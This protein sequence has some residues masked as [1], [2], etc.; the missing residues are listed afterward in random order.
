M[1]P[2]TP[3][4][5]QIILARTGI[6]PASNSRAL[7]KSNLIKRFFVICTLV[8]NQCSDPTLVLWD[9]NPG[10]D[11]GQ[12]SCSQIVSRISESDFWEFADSWNASAPTAMS[13]SSVR[14]TKFFK[15]GSNP[16]TAPQHSHCTRVHSRARPT[17]SPI[18]FQLDLIQ[19]QNPTTRAGFRW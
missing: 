12:L 18:T 19:F 4:R 9:S 7:A 16:H 14:T 8:L 13:I 3:S 5:M 2:T 17:P 11:P 15:S 6:E 10:F 1:L